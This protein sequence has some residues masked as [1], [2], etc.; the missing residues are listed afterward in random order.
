MG[1]RTH[2]GFVDACLKSGLP[3]VDM[4]NA[5]KQPLSS[6]PKPKA[7]PTCPE[8][9]KHGRKKYEDLKSSDPEMLD[10]LEEGEEYSDELMNLRCNQ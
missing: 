2:C 10:I 7:N 4:S 8:Q 1:A 3:G 9:K 6:P 5:S